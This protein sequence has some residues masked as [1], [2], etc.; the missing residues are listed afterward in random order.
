MQKRTVLSVFNQKER[1]SVQPNSYQFLLINMQ[2]L[3]DLQ[4]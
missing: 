2:H 1:F 4:Y 3:S